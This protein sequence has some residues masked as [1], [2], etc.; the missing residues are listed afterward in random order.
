MYKIDQKV[1]IGKI[2]AANTDLEKKSL[3]DS[4]L[5]KDLMRTYHQNA[6]LTETEWA[7][8]DDLVIKTVHRACQLDDSVRNSRWSIKKIEFDNTFGYGKD[9]VIDFDK[10]GG[11][12]GIFGKNRSG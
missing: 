6:G 1:D 11:V 7:T 3:R 2:K 10:I 8:F 5:Q 4:T 9:N 12:T